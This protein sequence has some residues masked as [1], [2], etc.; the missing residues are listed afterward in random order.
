MD[1]ASL[2][3]LAIVLSFAFLA[4]LPLGFLREGAPRLSF[5]WFLYIHLSIPFIILLRL[6]YGFS[7][8]I[9]PLTIACAVCGQIMGGRLFRRRNRPS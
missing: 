9:F 8:R 2:F 6:G 1:H 7:W 3:P 5:R 4:N